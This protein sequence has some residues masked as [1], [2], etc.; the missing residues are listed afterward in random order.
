MKALRKDAKDIN[1]GKIPSAVSQTNKK[2]NIKSNRNKMITVGEL[3]SNFCK[4]LR[5]ADKNGFAVIAKDGKPCSILIATSED[6]LVEDIRAIA[7][8][9]FKHALLRSQILAA[10]NEFYKMT[11]EDID[12]EI[13][14]ARKAR[15]NKK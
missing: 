10:K 5:E 11:M 13:A 8:V 14:A 7:H 9:K 6:T 15:K 1:S 3:A 4:V 2:V 12:A